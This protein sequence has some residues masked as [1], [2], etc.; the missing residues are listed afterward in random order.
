MQ[1]AYVTH[2]RAYTQSF[3]IQTNIDITMQHSCDNSPRFRS[4]ASL[5]TQLIKYDQRELQH[6]VKLHLTDKRTQQ[7]CLRQIRGG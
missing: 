5:Y 6:C 2:T 1:P 7:T 3:I 4:V